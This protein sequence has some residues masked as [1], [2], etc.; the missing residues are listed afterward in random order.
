MSMNTPKQGLEL[1]INRLAANV[2]ERMLAKG[3]ERQATLLDL[4]PPTYFIYPL[5]L[6]N[7]QYTGGGI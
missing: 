3:L 7:K 1:K 2:K 6:A 4:S 5:A